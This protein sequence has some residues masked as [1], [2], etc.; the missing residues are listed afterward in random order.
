MGAREGRGTKRFLGFIHHFPF[1]YAQ[2]E[3]CL[4]S[5]GS[6]RCYSEAILP[7][8][9]Y[10]FTWI[11]K[12]KLHNL[13]SPS[14]IEKREI[15]YHL[16]KQK[17]GANTVV[18]DRKNNTFTCNRNSYLIRISSIPG[19]Y[20]TPA[21]A[22]CCHGCDMKTFFPLLVYPLKRKRFA[23]FVRLLGVRSS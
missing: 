1:W 7:S 15:R 22:S 12:I 21:T 20:H 4:I 17:I 16:V 23:H 6:H 19:H 11:Q 14:P 3:G 5:S 18:K 8:P 13:L 9:M 2:Y 10:S